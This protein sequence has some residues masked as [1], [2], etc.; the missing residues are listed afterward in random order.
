MLIEVKSK[1]TYIIDG[2]T[3]KKSETFILDKEVFAQAE[4]AV[5]TLLSNQQTEGTVDSYELQ[6]LKIASVKEINTQYQG[7]HSY[8]ASLKDTFTDEVG[9]EKQIK[10]KILLWAN[11]IS[12]AMRNTREIARQG[13]DMQ[14]EGLKE[15][16]YQY[17]PETSESSESSEIL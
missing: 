1:V 12:E 5:M 16:N 10:Y 9:N 4:Y 11:T 8:I 14:I 2:K 6:L 13:Y 3:K 17:L 15:V 7:E